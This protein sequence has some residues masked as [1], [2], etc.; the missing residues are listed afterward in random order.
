M[1]GA[2]PHLKAYKADLNKKERDLLDLLVHE[3]AL[4]GAEWETITGLMHPESDPRELTTG[5]HL[6][7]NYLIEDGVQRVKERA[8]NL[9]RTGPP[10]QVQGNQ[11]HRTGERASA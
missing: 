1:A 7:T 11:V 6:L 4:S 3:L 5:E 10:A 8:G 2:S 9:I